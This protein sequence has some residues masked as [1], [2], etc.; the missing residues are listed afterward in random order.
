MTPPDAAQY[1]IIAISFVLIGAILTLGP[2][3]VEQR[4]AVLAAILG[5]LSLVAYRKRR[6]E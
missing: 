4:A 2:V 5:A 3:S 6:N 1:A